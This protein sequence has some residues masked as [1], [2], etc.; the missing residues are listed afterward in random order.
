MWYLTTKSHAAQRRK[1]DSVDRDGI[2]AM[3]RSQAHRASRVAPRTGAWIETPDA[4]WPA[5]PPDVAPRT[6]VP[7]EAQC[8]A[9]RRGSGAI[10]TGG[11]PSPCRLVSGCQIP[12]FGTDQGI[13]L[14][15]R[16]AANLP[17]QENNQIF[18]A[19]ISPSATHQANRRKQIRELTSCEQG[20]RTN[21]APPNRE[22]D[23]LWHRPLC[24]GRR[25]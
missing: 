16:R 20:L 15:P 17:D 3:V 11:R 18:N 19:L 21:V 23:V 22:I 12:V 6:G 7:L 1:D 5:P 10:P 25:P 9:A 8:G 2:V 14:P 13:F 24:G 4:R